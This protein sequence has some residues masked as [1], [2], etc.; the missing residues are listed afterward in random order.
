MFFNDIKGRIKLGSHKNTI[1]FF[2]VTLVGSLLPLLLGL[3][4]FARNHRWEGWT[5]FYGKGEFYL[6]SAALLTSAGYLFYSFKVKNYD[7]FSILFL[8]T[9]GLIGIDAILYAFI[10]SDKNPPDHN[11]LKYTSLGFFFFAVIVFYI[12]NYM[13]YRYIDFLEKE[14]TEIQDIKNQLP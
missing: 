1:P 8:I 3:L 9:F 10:L 11:F 2:I 5:I 12:S 14:K 6:Y 13:N 4:F 7:I